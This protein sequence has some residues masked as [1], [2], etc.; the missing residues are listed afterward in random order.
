MDELKLYTGPIYAC[1]FPYTDFT[2]V[3][4]RLQKDCV[5]SFTSAIAVYYA[6]S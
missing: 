1:I 2:A 3:L 6:R 5:T 4:T